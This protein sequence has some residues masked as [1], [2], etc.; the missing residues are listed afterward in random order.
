LR[1]AK[2]FTTS[3]DNSCKACLSLLASFRLSTKFV[4]TCSGNNA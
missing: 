4:Y 1:V 2:Q 3:K